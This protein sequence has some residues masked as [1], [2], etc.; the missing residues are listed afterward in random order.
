MVELVN[1]AESVF[2]G[3][4]AVEK[5]VLDEAVECAK[6]RE[7]ASE[8]ADAVHESERACDFA[9]AFEDAL[10]DE[11]VGLCVAEGAVDVCP[12]GGD[13][14]ADLWAE[15]EV[16]EL[17]VLEEAEKSRWIVFENIWAGGKQESVA[18]DEAV[19]FFAAFFP[20][21]KEGAEAVFRAVVLL[22]LESLH[23]GGG[24]AVEVAGVA[25]VVAHE[26]LGAA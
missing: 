22:D 23:Q 5:L 8:D 19:E 20:E 13:E 4:V 14:A 15:F 2:V 16:A 1:A 9:F 10:E 25:V 6:L 24:V 21:G 3:G 11:A 18:S 17:A 26:G 12:V 7:V